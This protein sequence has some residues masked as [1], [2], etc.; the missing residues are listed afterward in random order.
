[1]DTLLVEM[2]GQAQEQVAAW[3]AS[4]RYVSG[5]ELA[6]AGLAEMIELV[7]LPHFETNGAASHFPA[8]RRRK[9]SH[10]KHAAITH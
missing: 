9:Q 2:F 6:A 3:L 4:G 10:R 5:R 1:M 8:R 7:P